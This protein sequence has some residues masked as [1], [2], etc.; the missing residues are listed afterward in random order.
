MRC[1]SYIRYPE[2]VLSL[3]QSGRAGRDPHYAELAKVPTY[4]LR[5]VMNYLMLNEYLAVTKDE[6]AVVKFTG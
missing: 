1:T 4:K 6:Y 5:Q 2:A 3:T